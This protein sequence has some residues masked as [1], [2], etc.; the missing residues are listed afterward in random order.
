MKGEKSLLFSRGFLVLVMA[1]VL[2]RLAFIAIPGN[3]LQT[4]W[5]GGSDTGA[6]VLLAQNLLGGEGYTYAGQPTAFRPPGY[7]LLL[8]TFMEFFG[9]HYVV[10]MR[11][12]QFL[13]G[14]AVVLLCAAMAGRIFGKTAKKAALLLGLFLPTLVE[15][16]GEILTEMTAALLTGVFL[17]FLVRYR[18]KQRWQFLVGMSIAV[19]LGSLV[20]PNLVFLELVALLV[21]CLQKNGSTRLRGAAIIILAPCILMSPWIVRNLEVFHGRVLFSTQGGPAAATGI[22][23]PQ[24]RSQVGDADRIKDA[25]GWV[26]PQVLETNDPSRLLL[27]GEPEIDRRSWQVAY[28]LWRESG[29][30]L[31]PIGLKKI[32]YF[33]LSTDQIFWT[34]SLPSRQRIL[35]AIGVFA[36]WTILALAV[37]G[38]FSLRT[39]RPALAQVFLMYMLLVTVL[40]LPFN[41]STRYRIPLMD[42]LLVVLAAGTIATL[43]DRRSGRT[44]TQLVFNETSKEATMKP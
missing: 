8:A 28:H 12:F 1:G 21:V 31:V 14:L 40:H 10:A 13:E 9:K 15:L 27:P 20:R 34:R 41:M 18:E 6:Y 42:P 29:W 43:V 3:A 25:L 30:G 36:Y 22:I 5:S 44:R 24:G 39:E 35:R 4:P 32:S 23:E 16:T 11:G 33:W 7:P 37:V 2:G 17:Y 19:G 26:L 38:W